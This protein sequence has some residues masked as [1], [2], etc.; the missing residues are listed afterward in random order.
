MEEGDAEAAGEPDI[1]R[2]KRQ[3]VSC[4]RGV[5]N[6]RQSHYFEGRRVSPIEPIVQN[7]AIS[8]TKC[9]S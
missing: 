7:R 3:G 4:L 8:P 9:S 1:E 2:K 5:A 6:H